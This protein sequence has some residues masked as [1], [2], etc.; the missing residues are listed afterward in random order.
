MSPAEIRAWQVRVEQMHGPPQLAFNRELVVAVLEVA[1]QLA[2]L[3][4]KL[5]PGGVST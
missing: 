1:L 4:E 2:L 5:P 3:L